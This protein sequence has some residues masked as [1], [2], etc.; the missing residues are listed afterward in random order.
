MDRQYFDDDEES[1]SD[2]DFPYGRRSIRCSAAVHHTSS[3]EVAGQ[4]RVHQLVGCLPQ[5]KAPYT[6]MIRPWLRRI[7]PRI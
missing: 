7:S 2:Q 3:P 1:D 6:L 4:P 5:V